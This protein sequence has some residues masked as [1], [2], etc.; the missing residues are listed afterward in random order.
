MY[1][2]RR[3]KKERNLTDL[4]NTNILRQFDF[5]VSDADNT[6][7]ECGLLSMN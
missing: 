5:R 2:G 7:N 6:S 3:K 4:I 1:K